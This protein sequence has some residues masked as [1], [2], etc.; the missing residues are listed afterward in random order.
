MI[1][2]PSDHS[3]NS[4]DSLDFKYLNDDEQDP[5]EVKVKVEPKIDQ[6]SLE[7]CKTEGKE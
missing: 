7:L 5:E 4:M 6:A 1:S 2:K 3:D